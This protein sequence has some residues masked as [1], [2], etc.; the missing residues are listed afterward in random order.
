MRP[1]IADQGKWPT[2]DLDDLD[3]ADVAGTEGATRVGVDLPGKA[4]IAPASLLEGL[5]KARPA[6]RT[7][8]MIAGNCGCG[9][10]G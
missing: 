5:G 8:L 3:P 1:P 9:P 2:G 4:R 7:R 6:D 10:Q